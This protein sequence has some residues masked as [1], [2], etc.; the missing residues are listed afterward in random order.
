MTLSLRQWTVLG[1]LIVGFAVAALVARGGG[2]DGLPP[3]DTVQWCKGAEGLEGAGELFTGEA[4]TVTP[5]DA[6]AVKE[7]IF[8]VEILAPYEIRA[9]LARL[10]DFMI[11]LEQQL[12]DGEWP[13]AFDAAR[14]QVDT[15]A[16]DSALL[17]LET[18]M[19]RCGLELGT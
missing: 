3:I 13:G 5:A 9:D 4:T 17:A 1:V 18:E 11:V 8:S 19:Q 10:A 14:Q 6:D 7:A 2:G 12:A 15:D 16:V